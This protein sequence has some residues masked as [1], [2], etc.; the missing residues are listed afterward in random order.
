[1]IISYDI[2]FFVLSL[3]TAILGANL[4][5]TFFSNIEAVRKI[6]YKLRIVGGATAIGGG[7]WG[8][9]FM[10]MVALTLPFN[11]N[12]AVLP[13]LISALIA[14]IFTGLGLYAA[15]SGHLKKYSNEIGAVLIG[16]GISTMHYTGMEAVRATCVITYSP[17]ICVASVLVSIALSWWALRFIRPGNLSLFDTFCASVILGLS[18]SAVHYIA[19]WGTHFSFAEEVFENTGAA[20]GDTYIMSVVTVIV[21]LMSNVLLLVILPNER[22]SK[23]SQLDKDSNLK[24]GNEL[25]SIHSRL[26]SLTS[27]AYKS[28]NFDTYKSGYRITL[29]TNFAEEIRPDLNTSFQGNILKFEGFKKFPDFQHG[30]LGKALKYHIPQNTEHEL[31]SGLKRRTVPVQHHNETHLIDSKDILYISSDGHYTYVCF[32]N[33]AG[34]VVS[35]MCNMPISKL[36]EALS[37]YGFLR[38]HRKYLANIEA[39]SGYRRKGEAGLLIFHERNVEELPISRNRFAQICSEL[40]KWNGSS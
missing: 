40:K 28:M 30:A 17:L 3:I 31:R 21:F 8:M 7:I 34:N 4:G 20:L 9:H 12:Y 10:G 25:H 39:V 22:G 5:F 1:M 16:G 15:T 29:G 27:P 11:V 32:L 33:N 38:I 2:N 14:I 6:S 36:D 23:V 35:W 13:T 19:M 24:F 26:I 37:P 18:I